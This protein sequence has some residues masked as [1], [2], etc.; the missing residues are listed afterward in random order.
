MTDK[1]VRSR[2]EIDFLLFEISKMVEAKL[3]DHGLVS[4][5]E[6][7]TV[8]EIYRCEAVRKWGTLRKI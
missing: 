8:Q 7:M 6:K 3:L 1:D 5:S 2:G 4:I